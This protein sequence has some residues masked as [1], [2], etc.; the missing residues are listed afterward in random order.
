[1]IEEPSK[2]LVIN[3]AGSS[4]SKKKVGA[5]L[6]NK[7]KVVE[8]ATNL[9]NKTHPLQA[10]FAELA[11]LGDKIYLH[12]EISALVKCRQE[13]DTIVVAR[14]GGH[15]HDEMRMAKPCPVCQLALEQAGIRKV[16]YSTNNGF[17]TYKIN[18]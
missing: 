6:M 9:D 17:I 4:T 10:R 16:Y 13:C 1:M 7:N 11:G 15:N 12:A 3:I 14:L 18:K 2:G 5:V 8:W